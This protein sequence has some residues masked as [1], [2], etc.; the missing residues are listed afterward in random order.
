MHPVEGRVRVERLEA[1]RREFHLVEYGDDDRGR[2]RRAPGRRRADV[3]GCLLRLA[4]NGRINGSLWRTV[5]L[6][7]AQGLAEKVAVCTQA[8]Q[9]ETEP[10]GEQGEG[11]LRM[12]Q[13]VADGGAEVFPALEVLA[14]DETAFHVELTPGF[15]YPVKFLEI[16]GGVVQ[17]LDDLHHVD[18]VDALV[19]D[20]SELQL[21]VL[22]DVKAFDSSGGEETAVLPVAASEIHDVLHL[23]GRLVSEARQSC[24]V[25]F[26]GMSAFTPLVLGDK[27]LGVDRWGEHGAARCA[28]IIGMV[29]FSDREM[30]DAA[31]DGAD[32]PGLRGWPARSSPDC[33]PAVFP[34]V[35]VIPFCGRGLAVIAE[36]LNCSR[37]T[38]LVSGSQGF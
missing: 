3:R 19:G 24:S 23:E 17:V 11:P 18:A 22:V 25:H 5:G 34:C 38:V 20:V 15:Q 16:R 1:A 28:G 35:P 10:F 29:L 36:R 32:Y 13:A 33:E 30:R 7:G 27:N 21:R 2:G 6:P 26:R 9:P 8:V 4:I 14:V 31:A 12:N 37:D